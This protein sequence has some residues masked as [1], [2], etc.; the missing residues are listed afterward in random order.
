MQ[1]TDPLFLFVAAI[2]WAIVSWQ[3]K[4][5]EAQEQET[6]AR[7]SATEEARQVRPAAAGGQ[8]PSPPKTSSSGLGWEEELRR[9]LEGGPIQPK[10]TPAPVPKP[11]ST[12]NTGSAPPPLP[13]PVHRPTASTPP[14]PRPVSRPQPLPVRPPEPEPAPPPAPAKFAP[15]KLVSD[16]DGDYFHK[17]AC[18][19]CG[20]RLL[21]PQGAL[22]HTLNCPHCNRDTRLQPY[23]ASAELPEESAYAVKRRPTGSMAAEVAAM[24]GSSSAAQRAVVASIVFGPPKALE[25]GRDRNG[26]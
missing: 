15:P 14:V 19:H 4:R 11:V 2:V 16:I 23:L 6:K 13:P 21:F 25:D 20:G 5:R 1:G 26:F 7:R 3:Q 17:G 24:F 22:G 9:L 8:E 10:P 18:E 12:P